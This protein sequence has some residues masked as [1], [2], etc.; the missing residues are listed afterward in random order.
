M[1]YQYYTRS[2]IMEIKTNH[3]LSS[4]LAIFCC[5]TFTMHNDR[6]DF[7]ATPKRGANIF[8][9]HVTRDD[10]RAAKE[11]DIQFIRLAPD[12]FITKH[13]DFL[14]GNADDYCELAEDDLAVLISL[15]DLCAQEGMRVVL[16][17]LTLPFSRW[18]QNNDNN[19]DLS[20]WLNLDNMARAAKF[21]QDVSKSLKNHPAIIAFNILNEP[22][23]EK[24]WPQNCKNSQSYNNKSAKKLAQFNQI[25]I[26]AIRNIDVNI[27]IIVDSGN[28][29]DPQAFNYLV[30]S[31]DDIYILYSFHMYEPYSYTNKQIN[32]NRYTYPGCVIDN[33]LWNNNALNEYI[34]PV[35]DF[36]KKFNIPSNRILVGEFGGHNSCPGLENYFQDLLDIFI[37]NAWHYAF[38]SFNE[39]TWDG[40]NY[41]KVAAGTILKKA[42]SD[43]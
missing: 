42:Y 34:K 9:K 41:Q 29:A 8:N 31:P 33:I 39:D 43:I 15:L 20:L 32:N 5:S 2:I 25:I 7:W 28:Y 6:M 40:I 21:W 30:P 10:I 16:T 38:Y 1:V 23:P 22:H 17:M 18:K 12:K 24:L 27:P 3:F 36:Q 37:H 26:Q 35:L 14:I 19:D 13:R 4:I 11:Y